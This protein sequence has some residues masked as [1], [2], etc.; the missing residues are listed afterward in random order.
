MKKQKL[1]IIFCL[2]LILGVL[3]P[4]AYVSAADSVVEP[5]I[6]PR[7]SYISSLSAELSISSAGKTTDYG[8][9]RLSDSKLFFDFA[10]HFQS[11]NCL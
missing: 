5:I 6:Q 1:S 3:S 2:V 11:V 8:K 4:V 10:L 7:Y 9:V